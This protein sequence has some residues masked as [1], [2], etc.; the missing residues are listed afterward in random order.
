M[1]QQRSRAKDGTIKRGIEW[2]DYTWNPVTG[3]FHRCQWKMPNGILAHCYADNVAKNL[4]Q[5]AYP[6]G[7]E[8]HYWYPKEIEAPFTRR[9]PSKIFVGSM[10]DVFGAWVPEDQIRQILA[11]VAQCPQ[12]TFQFLTKNLKRTQQFNFPKN[13]WLGVSSPPSFFKRKE[14]SLQDKVDYVNEALDIFDQMPPE[15]V[16]WMSIEPLSFNIAPLIEQHPKTL[17][18]VV[19]GAASEASTFYQP[20]EDD[21]KSLMTV[22][23][24]HRVPH[25]FKGN[26]RPSLDKGTLTEWAEMWANEYVDSPAIPV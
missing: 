5:V 24:T 10:T 6:K 3:C 22:L 23:K 15:T 21:L 2:T 25:F 8:H 18:W 12:H 16:K 20:D 1:N 11:M 17:N 7:F 9:K 4:A 26:L 13:V 19:V 14:L